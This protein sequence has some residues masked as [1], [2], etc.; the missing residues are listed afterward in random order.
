ML[1]AA[2]PVATTGSIGAHLKCH[3]TGERYYEQRR[4]TNESLPDSHFHIELNPAF[5]VSNPTTT[6]HETN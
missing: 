6:S 5:R 3:A 1:D 4:A 2:K